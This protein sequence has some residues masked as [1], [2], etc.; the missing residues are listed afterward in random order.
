MILFRSKKSFTWKLANENFPSFGV[1]K[2]RR[3]L[4]E[5]FDDW[6]K[7]APLSFREASW[8]EEADFDI[9][10]VHNNHPDGQYFVFRPLALAYAFLPTGGKA[11]FSLAHRWTDK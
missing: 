2:I 5:S 7:H 3:Q 9:A 1:A 6:A 8:N 11:R 4:R 10:F